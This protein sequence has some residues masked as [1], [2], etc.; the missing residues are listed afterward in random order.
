MYCASRCIS[1]VF[2]SAI[3][4]RQTRVQNFRRKKLFIGAQTLHVG[5]AQLQNFFL[6]KWLLCD[7][8]T[9]IVVQLVHRKMW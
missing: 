1:R 6:E 5:V 9:Y 4:D 3:I 8:A 2:F 7:S